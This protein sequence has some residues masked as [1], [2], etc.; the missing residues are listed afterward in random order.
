MQPSAP[1]RP[2]SV[3]VIGWAAIGLGCLSV[4][5]GAGAL[6][7]S[8][9][10]SRMEGFPPQPDPYFPTSW[11]THIRAVAVVQIPLA[12]LAAWAGFAFLR[13]RPWSRAALEVYAWV[14]LALLLAFTIEWVLLGLAIRKAI[15][16]ET[17]SSFPLGLFTMNGFISMLAFAT[18]N[19]IVIRTL[20]SRQV[21]EVFAKATHPQ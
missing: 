12:A 20:R 4:F 11:F 3:T 7:V 16:H 18:V 14:S 13:L 6:A 2:T 9:V 19:V 8:A 10:M 15:G 21:R 1:Q 5:S 17:S